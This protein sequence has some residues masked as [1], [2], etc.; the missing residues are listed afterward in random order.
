MNPAIEPAED[1]AAH[2]VSLKLTTYFAERKRVGSR[3]LAEAMLDLFAE[4]R[5]ATS[6]MLRGISGFGHRR[7]IR[8]DESLSLSEDPSVALVAVD[9][10]DTI[11]GLAGEV[12]A[13]T[14]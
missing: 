8:S 1:P 2:D 4:R 7:I 3:F 14:A 9:D 11:N 12:A 13:A 6:A 10:P 5:V